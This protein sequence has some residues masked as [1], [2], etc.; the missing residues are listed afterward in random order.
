MNIN[1]RTLWLLTGLLGAF[2]ATVAA[3][4]RGG[5]PQHGDYALTAHADTPGDVPGDITGEPE[6]INVDI[7]NMDDASRDANAEEEPEVDGAEPLEIERILFGGP[8]SIS[9]RLSE[10]DATINNRF[11]LVAH[12]PSYIMPFTWNFEADDASFADYDAPIDPLEM[13]FQ[14]SLK[15]PMWD[16]PVGEGSQ[17]SFGYTQQAWWQAY[18][19][20]VSRP[21]RET[22]HEPELMLD[23]ITDFEWL[24]FTNRVIRFG[25]NHHSN[26]RAEPR[27]RSWNRIY[28]EFL[29]E[30]G[31]FAMSF[32]PWVRIPESAEDDDNPDIQE[33]LGHFEVRFGWRN[34]DNNYTLMLRN[35]LESQGNRGAV[36]ATWSYGVNDKV[37]GY[38]QVFSGYGE[39]LI[40]YNRSVTRLGIGVQLTDWL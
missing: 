35:N 29:V 5:A 2:P 34:G 36:E 22:N 14:L 8:P 15:V 27:S 26:G 9:S 37:R 3:T 19:S 32:R 6:S 33:Y 7:D 24:G 12:R 28:A 21:F 40:D 31:S 38:V 16:E 25:L 18:N 39:S 11:A 20:E 4:T 10:E 1:L 23:L 13:K 17:L 30:R